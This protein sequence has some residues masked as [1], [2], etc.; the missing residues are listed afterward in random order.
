MR[1]IEKASFLECPP[2]SLCYSFS[3]KFIIKNR[4]NTFIKHVP[5]SVPAPPCGR[6]RT[7]V[8]SSEQPALLETEI[9]YIIYFTQFSLHSHIVAKDPNNYPNERALL[10]LHS[11][12]S[13]RIQSMSALRKNNI[14]RWGFS[15]PSS[16]YLLTK[17]RYLLDSIF[18]F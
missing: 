2:L 15:L 8:Q 16:A 9:Q 7:L 6:P 13:R 3:L 1:Y 10:I 11:L 18:H 12:W 4:N 14:N 17:K 5:A